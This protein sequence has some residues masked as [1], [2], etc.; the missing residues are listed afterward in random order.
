MVNCL[1]FELCVQGVEVIV[2][3]IY[4]GGYLIGGY[5]ECFVFFGVIVDIVN[6]LDCVVD[7]VVSGYMYQ[8]YICC[9]DGCLVISVDK[10]GNFVIVIDLK[11][12]CR[13]GDVILVQVENVFVDYKCF[14]FDLDI[15]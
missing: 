10:Y 4:E 6:K 3:L 9:I 14:Q 5:N 8:G 11:F 1:V 12:D 15:V 7:F 13:I 2:V